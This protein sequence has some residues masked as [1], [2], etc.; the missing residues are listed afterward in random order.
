MVEGQEIETLSEEESFLYNVIRLCK[1]VVPAVAGI[2]AKQVAD[3]AVDEEVMADL[4]STAF[5]LSAATERLLAIG[6]VRDVAQ[7]RFDAR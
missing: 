2:L 3:R 7:E 1:R 4:Q 5:V 6:A